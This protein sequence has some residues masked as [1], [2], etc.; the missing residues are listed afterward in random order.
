MSNR[1]AL[2]S[3]Y[4]RH[5]LREM[6]GAG[7]VLKHLA[8]SVGMSETTPSQILSGMGV[9]G[10]NEP[11]FARMFGLSHSQLVFAAETWAGSSGQGP[12]AESPL[13][14]VPPH[15]KAR[16]IA[17]GIDVLPAAIARVDAMYEGASYEGESER[18]WLE[19]YLAE[20]RMARQLREREGQPAAEPQKKIKLSPRSG[21]REPSQSPS[22]AHRKPA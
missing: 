14:A 9:G 13:R 21:P 5:R 15:A 8:Q 1:N 22:A 16:K 4:V 18:W 20:D 11:K 6:Q 10:V 2:V 7:A 19:H 12:S 3:E 17:Q